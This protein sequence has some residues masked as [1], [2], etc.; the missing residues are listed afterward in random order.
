MGNSRA[1]STGHNVMATALPSI[2][3]I[4]SSMNAHQLG[5]ASHAQA[6]EVDKLIVNVARA[7]SYET[8]KF[9][10]A[11]RISTAANASCIAAAL[12]AS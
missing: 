10:V 2:V 3:D 5:I 6:T 11:L 9:T 4:Q 12:P 8:I 1:L 7:E